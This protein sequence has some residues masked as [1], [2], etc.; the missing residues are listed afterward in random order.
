MRD[1][2]VYKQNDKV[3]RRKAIMSAIKAINRSM[4]TRTADL[5]VIDIVTAV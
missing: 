4:A 1:A 3:G 5:F 2:N